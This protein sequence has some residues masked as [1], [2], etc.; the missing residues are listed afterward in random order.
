[1]LTKKKSTALAFLYFHQNAKMPKCHSINCRSGG[2]RITFIH[3]DSQ[4]IF[5]GEKCALKS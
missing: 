2:Q 3:N 4:F 1:M 5:G